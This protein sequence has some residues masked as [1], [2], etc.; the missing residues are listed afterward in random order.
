M[1]IMLGLMIA[2]GAMK[3]KANYDAAS[4][5]ADAVMR[6][7]AEKGRMLNEIRRRADYNKYLVS[8]KESDLVSTQQTQLGASGAGGGSS[9]LAILRTSEE[10]NLR[11]REIEMEAG[12]ELDR[13]RAEIAIGDAQA[14]DIKKARGIGVMSDILSIGANTSSA[15]YTGRKKPKDSRS[16]PSQTVNPFKE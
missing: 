7:N 5:D 6:Q 10:A 13:L 3:A 14:R 9:I 11:R 8:R 12:S 4:A 16:L 1:S 15:Y 2:S